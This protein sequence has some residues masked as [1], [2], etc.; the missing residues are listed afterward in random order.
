MLMAQAKEGTTCFGYD[1]AIFHTILTSID[2]DPLLVSPSIEGL[3]AAQTKKEDSS[4]FTTFNASRL[5]SFQEC[6]VF[7]DRGT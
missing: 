7:K 2:E 6:V 3:A 4:I 1:P 5:D